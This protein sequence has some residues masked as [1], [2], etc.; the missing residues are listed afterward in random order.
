MSEQ[1]GHGN[2]GETITVTQPVTFS[3]SAV[4][5]TGTSQVVGGASSTLGF[6]GVT[7]V[8]RQSVTTVTAGGTTTAAKL[9]IAR[10]WTALEALGLIA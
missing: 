9:T 2:T 3:G 1:L 6:Y 5:F 8:A 7:A 4:S 10:V